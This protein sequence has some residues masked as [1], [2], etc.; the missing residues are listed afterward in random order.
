LK[1]D[2]VGRGVTIFLQDGS[3][4]ELIGKDRLPN[5]YTILNRLRFTRIF[6]LMKDRITA[7]RDLRDGLFNYCLNTDDLLATYEYLELNGLDVAKPISLARLRDDDVKIKWQ[8]I[9]SSPYDLPFFIG[10]YN[11]ARISDP[12]CT[13]HA[14]KA[15]SLDSIII[16]TDSFEK[17]YRI[18]NVIYNQT[19]EIELSDTL[20]TSTYRLTRQ[21]V[22][23]QETKIVNWFFT[24][25]DQSAPVKVFITCDE[26]P[27]ANKVN[28]F[29]SLTK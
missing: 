29:I 26:I 28:E 14:N 16:A 7:F 24:P 10:D 5:L 25:G 17:Y 4:I 23:L 12:L 9:G 3:A 22:I 13:Q 8:L 18:Y 15:L 1:Q 6:G 27:D 19:P 20:R 2:A 21:V 11:P